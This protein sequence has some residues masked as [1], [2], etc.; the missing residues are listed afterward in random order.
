MSININAAALSN[1][2][3]DRNKTELALQTFV[4]DVY[5]NYILDKDDKYRVS[6]TQKL[7]KELGR[8]NLSEEWTYEGF[9]IFG[10]GG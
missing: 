7:Q 1:S 4:Q 10:I 3:T 9:E 8:S 6:H 2:S 5:N